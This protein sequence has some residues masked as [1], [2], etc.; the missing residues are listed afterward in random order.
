MGPGYRPEEI[1]L[2]QDDPAQP[3]VS[4]IENLLITLYER[5]VKEDAGA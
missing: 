3:L 4:Q 5:V 2:V 1:I